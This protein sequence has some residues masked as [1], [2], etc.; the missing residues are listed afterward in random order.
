MTNSKAT[1]MS[2][3]SGLLLNKRLRSHIEGTNTL[4]LT[5]MAMTKEPTANK[6]GI[7]AKLRNSLRLMNHRGGLV[8]RK[9]PS[10]AKMPMPKKILPAEAAV[11]KSE[12]RN[13]ILFDDNEGIMA[14]K[15]V[16]VAPMKK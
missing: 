10:K 5:K 9:K 4:S 13:G 2:N 8:N 15:N 3:W 11:N 14:S 1:P 16:K 6:V 12:M 7:A